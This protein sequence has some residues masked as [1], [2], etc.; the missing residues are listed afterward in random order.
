[1]TP[2]EEWYESANCATTD[3]EIFFDPKD[4]GPARKVCGHCP[5][6][7]QCLRNVMAEEGTAH[8]SYRFGFVGG[9]T[10]YQRWKLSFEGRRAA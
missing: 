7:A 1:M 4:N 6:V 3:P 5:V 10:A 2:N 8:K 9:L